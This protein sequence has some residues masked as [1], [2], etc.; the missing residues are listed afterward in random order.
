MHPYT[1]D[2]K[3]SC[4]LF[5]SKWLAMCGRKHGTTGNIWWGKFWQTIQVKAIGEKKIGE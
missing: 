3:I 4:F 2:P 1:T 5:Y